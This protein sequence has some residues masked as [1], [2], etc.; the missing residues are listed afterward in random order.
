MRF[1]DVTEGKILI[2]GIDIK[3]YKLEK[4]YEKYD[5]ANLPYGKV[6]DKSLNHI[7]DIFR[8]FLIPCRILKSIPFIFYA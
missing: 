8:I 4:L 1:Y 2:D 7:E 3:D 6:H 5:I